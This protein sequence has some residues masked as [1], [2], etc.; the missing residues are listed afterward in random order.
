MTNT[1]VKKHLARLKYLQNM[2]TTYAHRW[3]EFPSTRLQGWVHEFNDIKYDY[4]EVW[5]IYCHNNKFAESSDGYD[6]LS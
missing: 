3:S 4:P 5:V 6:L 2:I 1:K